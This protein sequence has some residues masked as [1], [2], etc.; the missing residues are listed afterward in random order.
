MTTLSDL[1]SWQNLLLA[2]R[3][4]SKGKQGKAHVTRFTFYLEDNLFTL[5]QELLTG[6]YHPG[7]YDS[8]Y[9]HEPKCRLISAAP[10]R[11]RVIHHALCNLI[12][13]PFERS[14]IHDSYANRKGKGT[15]RARARVQAFA[16][17][18]PFALQ[19]DIKQFFPMIDHKT[20]KRR[21]FRKIK[22]EGI[23]H[24]IAQILDSGVGIH[25]Q[26]YPNRK[27]GLPI[28]NLTSQF[29]ANVYLS[30]MDHFVKRT[31]GCKGYVRYVDDFVLFAGCKAVLRIWHTQIEQFLLNN[32][33]LLH[34]GAHPKPVTEGLP[35]LGFVLYP[36]SIRLKKR[37]GI[38]YQRKLKR[39]VEAGVD[40]EA[41]QA[42]VQG[43]QN[44]VRYANTVGL[45]EAILSKI[46]QI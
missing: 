31:L 11:D 37:K 22:D 39:M 18:F 8:F 30:P 7:S 17:R 16:R 14:F 23:R 10:F 20:L 21:L 24:L 4:A 42:S 5:Q 9:I 27:T 29:W 45:Q 19:L 35:F 33:L 6:S 40:A 12:E 34:E 36:E 38:H 44:H 2:Y 26:H 32:Y 28:G 1:A 43:W 15:H 25:M 46:I 13:P 41:I 3:K